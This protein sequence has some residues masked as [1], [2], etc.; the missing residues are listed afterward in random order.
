M[1]GV[2]ADGGATFLEKLYICQDVDVGHGIGYGAG[3]DLSPRKGLCG[4]GLFGCLW[5]IV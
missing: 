5:L 3:G 1:G 2:F 4:S